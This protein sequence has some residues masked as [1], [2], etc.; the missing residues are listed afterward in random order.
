MLL[1]VR[2]ASFEVVNASRPHACGNDP[3]QKTMAIIIAVPLEITTLV[4]IAVLSYVYLFIWCH[5]PNEIQ[6]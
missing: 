6:R 3:N 1:I 2:S 4:C 5:S